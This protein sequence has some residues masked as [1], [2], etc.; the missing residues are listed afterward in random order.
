MY[1]A[2]YWFGYVVVQLL[3][4]A[5][6]S[7]SSNYPGNQKNLLEELTDVLP[8]AVMEP[9]SLMTMGMVGFQ[10]SR[11][12]EADLNHQRQSELCYCNVWQGWNSLWMV[13]SLEEATHEKGCTTAHP[14]QKCS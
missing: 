9:F 12:Q 2:Y 4:F 8:D 10:N 1:K 6:L 14:M 11:G 3:W 5:L 13:S 7:Q